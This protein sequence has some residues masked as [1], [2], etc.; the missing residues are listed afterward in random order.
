[1]SIAEFLV[2]NGSQ[3]EPV[4]YRPISL[5]SH[6]GKIFKGIHKEYIVSHLVAHSFSNESQHGFMAKRSCLTNLVEFMK[7]V[8]DAVDHGKP[9]D[10]IYLD[11]QN[12]FDKVP[13]RYYH[14]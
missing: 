5:T 14:L 6:L 8:T 9:V 10:V 12:A 4:N 11:F 13:H 1:M 3:S 7:Y 2:K